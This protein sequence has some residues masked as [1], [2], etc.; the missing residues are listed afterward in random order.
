MQQAPE[1][2]PR[3]GARARIRSVYASLAPAEQKVAD[4]CLEQPEEVVYLSVTELADLCGVA[5]STVIRFAHAAGFSGYQELKLTLVTD[6]ALSQGAEGPVSPDDPVDVF[7]DKMTRF[8]V[9]VLEDTARLLDLHQLE[10]AIRVLTEA[11]R[12]E[13]YGVGAS[14]ITALD[15]KYKFLRI[16]KSCDAFTDSHL[17]AMSAANLRKGDVA[18]GISQTGSTQDTVD[19]VS[20]AKERG[21]TVICITGAARSPITRVADITLLTSSVESPLEGG[22]LRTKIAQIH[23]LDLLYTGVSMRLGPS[24]QEATER[25]ARAVLDK[26]Y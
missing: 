21:A 15:A 17:Q 3:G 13:F 11:P 8:N 18:V 1:R 9:Q 22:A 16:G 5:E 4:Y 24:A 10:E 14:G 25:T 19:S 6:A 7:A 2:S 26:L 23:V 20:V 12:V